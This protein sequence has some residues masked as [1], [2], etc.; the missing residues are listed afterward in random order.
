MYKYFKD[1]FSSLSGLVFLPIKWLGI[2]FYTFSN[3]TNVKPETTSVISESGQRC[4]SLFGHVSKQKHSK[5]DSQNHK[6]VSDSCLY[7]T[8]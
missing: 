6:A 7:K 2:H 3:L 4:F 5:N 8:M 1:H